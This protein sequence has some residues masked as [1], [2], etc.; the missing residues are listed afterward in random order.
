MG[1]ITNV[2]FLAKSVEVGDILVIQNMF[3]DLFLD[4]FKGE[5][6]MLNEIST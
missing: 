5:S 4:P 6:A 2:M 1:P 3:P